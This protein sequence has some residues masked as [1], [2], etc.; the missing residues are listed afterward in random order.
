VAL[1][2][3]IRKIRFKDLQARQSTPMF[4]CQSKASMGKILSILT[5]VISIQ[6]P[7]MPMEISTLGEEAHQHTT[8][9]NVVTDI[10]MQLKFLKKLNCSLQKE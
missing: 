5:V 9:A 6:L 1:S 4:L 3:K 2:S 8:K 10:P 7:L